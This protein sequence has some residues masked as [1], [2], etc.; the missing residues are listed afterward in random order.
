MKI[1]KFGGSS[2]G[3]PERVKSVIEIVKSKLEEG[4]AGV[5][6]SAYSGVTDTLIKTGQLAVQRDKSYSDIFEG[7][8]KKHFEFASELVPAGKELDLLN[9]GLSLRFTELKEILDGVYLLKEL[10]PKT[11]DY[12]Q[13][14]GE[15]L[16]AYTITVAFR[17]AGVNAG[18][19]DARKVIK[20]DNNFNNAHILET[21][22][23]YFIGQEMKR[24]QELRV[25]TGFIASTNDNET[26][27]LGRG[28]SDFT[29][30]IFG[31][32]INAGEIEIW[33]D[34]DGV[35]TADPRKVS[36][37]FIVEE[38]SY[39]E[40]MELSYFGAKVIYAPTIQPAMDRGIPV[41]IKNTFNPAHPGSIIKKDPGLNTN[42]ITGLACIDAIALVRVEGGGMVG[43]SGIAGRL[44]RSLAKEKINVILITQASSEHS[45]S[46]AVEPKNSTAAVKI[47]REEFAEELRLGRISSI[48]KEEGLASIAVVGANMRRRHGVAGRVFDTLGK[49][50]INIHAIAQGSSELN[51]SFVIA[52]DKLKQAM[53]ALHNEF[54]FDRRK[55]WDIYLAGPGNVGSKFI[56]L[57]RGK[58]DT[59]DIIKLKGV[60]S[61]SKMLFG[62]DILGE[63]DPVDALR[64]GGEKASSA[65][66]LEQILADENPFKV[67]VDCTATEAT[68]RYYEPLLKAGVHIVA[69]NKVANAAEKGFYNGLHEAGKTGDSQFLYETNVGAALPVIKVLQDLLNAGDRIVKIEGIMS[70]S[71]NH[72]L[73]EVWS[74]K[75]FMEAL[76]EAKAA[77]YTEPDPLVDLSGVDVA[78]KLLILV[79]ETG[80][81]V[82]MEDVIVEPLAW[83]NITGA[84]EYLDIDTQVQ[85]AKN[86]GNR[87]KFVAS[88]SE[89]K[90]T[91]GPR[92]VT[93]EDPLYSVNGVRNAF[94]FYTT[95]YSEFPLVISGP[96]AGVA[97]TA[98]GVMNDLLS[99]M[100]S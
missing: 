20:T 1:L 37:S 53:S 15:M 82:S 39:E 22:T 19:L 29:A 57:L 50:R 74:G 12:I 93:P 35:L 32:A 100:G 89:G 83:K 84:V 69:A 79:R 23:F 38:L 95:L 91:V 78:R 77:G 47:L 10:T 86:R 27:T 4:I 31:A 28:G 61:S 18:F 59:N 2:V 85:E 24:T 90:M 41:R 3:S 30:A 48:E 88:Y 71:L 36:D 46:L 64:Q 6:F 63:P 76:E 92:E 9:E 54:F 99:I 65:K 70:G 42:E 5:V 45:I 51:I 60:I 96:G 75:K 80:V 8:R 14:F 25:I 43:V 73:T 21:E 66:F 81:N 11:L 72:I 52:A 17:G 34:V 13:S 56:S 40:A 16:S 58:N 67:F 55:V 87:I 94:I 98:A 44:F 49:H 26:T 7:L 62:D 68:L 97:L 33:T